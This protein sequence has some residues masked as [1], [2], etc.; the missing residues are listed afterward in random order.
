M[1][2]WNRSTLPHV[3]GWLGREFFWRTPRRASSVSSPLRPPLPPA[4]RVVKTMPLSVS[5]ETGIP[6]AATHAWNDATTMGPVTRSWTVTRNALREW[7]SSQDRIS[8]STRTAAWSR[9][10]G[11]G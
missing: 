3:V 9:P 4:N 10:V 6:W 1:V 11:S 5:V 8:M 2:C 7:S